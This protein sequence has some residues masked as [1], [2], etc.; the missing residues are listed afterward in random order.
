MRARRRWFMATP[1]SPMRSSRRGVGGWRARCDDGGSG[2]G[3]TVAIMAPNVP[4][5]LEAHY[6]VPM[7]GAVLNPLNYRLDARSIAFILEHGRA[8][9]LIVDREFSDVVG[10][11]L[12]LLPRAPSRWWTSTIRSAM[13]PAVVLGR[14]TMR[15]FSQRANPMRVSRSPGD[16]WQAICLLYTSGTTG[17]PKGVVYHH[18][19]AYLNALGNAARLWALAALGLSVDLPDVPLQRLDVHLGGDGSGG[20]AR[21]PAPGRSGPDL[22]RHRPPPGDASLRGARGAQ[23]AHPR[24]GRGEGEF[25]H[26]VEVATGGAAPPSTVIAAMESMGFRVTT[27]MG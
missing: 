19:G 13:A 1:G 22:P 7:V 15:G 21:V 8:R 16:E 6:G 20:H 27:S 12:R 17:N 23:H 5:L 2:A 24:A 11:A 3:D 14:P 26:E 4:A 18:R 9:L 10:E 25:D